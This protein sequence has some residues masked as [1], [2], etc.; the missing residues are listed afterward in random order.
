[1]NRQ[2]LI[3]KLESRPTPRRVVLFAATLILAL[4][5]LSAAMSGESGSVQRLHRTDA[6]NWLEGAGRRAAGRNSIRADRRAD[7]PAEL[8]RTHT[9][10]V[11]AAPFTQQPSGPFSIVPLVNSGGESGRGIPFK[12]VRTHF[13]QS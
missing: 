8:V 12:A 13:R 1:M 6:A 3:S 11:I 10:N 7:H 4:A 9:R 2:E 5:P